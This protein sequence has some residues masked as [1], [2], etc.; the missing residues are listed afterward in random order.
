MDEMRDQWQC[1]LTF[2]TPPQTATITLHPEVDPQLSHFMQLPF[3]TRVKLQ[4][5]PH[6]LPSYNFKRASAVRPITAAP[7]AQTASRARSAEVTVPAQALSAISLCGTRLRRSPVGET[8]GL[9][10]SR[11]AC[12]WEYVYAFVPSMGVLPPTE[13]PANLI[14]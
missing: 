14:G 10:G 6:G 13:A 3:R 8:A 12:V 2:L 1:F 7:A 5:L 4:H 9:S 11:P